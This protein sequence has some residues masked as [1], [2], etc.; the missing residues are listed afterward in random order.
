[1]SKDIFARYS[2]QVFIEEIGL[3]GQRKIINSKVL[4]IGA[5]GLGSPVIQY[6]AAAG[7]G[8][9]GVADFDEV[10]LHNLNRQ[11]IHTENTVGTAK[12]KSVELFVKNLNHQVSF[13]GIDQKI[14]PS[15]A[16]EILSQYDIIV[17]GSDNFSTRYLIN[18]T[19][20]RLG[21]P[22]IYG[23]IL[24]FS[25]QVAIFNYKGSKNLRDL[26]PEPPSDEDVPDCDSLGV[27]GALPGIVGSM[28]AMNTLKMITE[29]PVQTDQLTLIDTLSWRF[30]TIDF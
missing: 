29:L 20:T 2:R 15:N 3:E 12:V 26:F 24:G 19:C 10:E 9:L 17:D 30:Q 21:K 8:N 5:G 7:V 4:V 28:M 27:L 14:N 22:L 25:G 6:L 13:T 23:S 18:D 11:I 1:M 16:K